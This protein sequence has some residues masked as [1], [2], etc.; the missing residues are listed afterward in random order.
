VEKCNELV[1]ALE[2][3][4]R[5]L[6]HGLV[7]NRKLIGDSEIL[8]IELQKGYN[9][10]KSYLDKLPIFK[11]RKIFLEKAKHE[12]EQQ[13]QLTLGE[14]TQVSRPIVSSNQKGTITI[15]GQASMTLPH[16]NWESAKKPK[17]LTT[18]DKR[19]AI[20]NPEGQ[21][22]VR[23]T[24]GGKQQLLVS[25]NLIP[26]SYSAKTLIMEKTMRAGED[27][28]SQGESDKEHEVERLQP[29]VLAKPSATNLLANENLRKTSQAT[30]IHRFREIHSMLSDL[31]VIVTPAETLEVLVPSFRLVKYLKEEL[32]KMG[33]TV[34]VVPISVAAPSIKTDT[35]KVDMIKIHWRIFTEVINSLLKD[36]TKELN[37]NELEKILNLAKFSNTV[38]DQAKVLFKSIPM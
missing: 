10:F 13:T 18:E 38:L 21:T 19:I 1:D 20:S 7:Y 4:R 15:R 6:E 25:D 26:H 28:D 32:V 24:S 12:K 11:E 27:T 3:L 36:I 31:S 29:S 23:K 9:D 5:I 2:S 30:V 37:I 17:I 34:G 22:N 14:R 8:Q 33:Y 35:N 16:G